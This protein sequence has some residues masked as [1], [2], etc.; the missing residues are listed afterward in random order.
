L[1]FTGYPTEI[2]ASKLYVWNHFFS[3]IAVVKESLTTELETK[4]NHLTPALCGFAT[5]REVNF[6]RV[7]Q[8]RNCVAHQEV[9]DIPLPE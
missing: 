3:D 6:M 5:L 4:K 7:T 1:D 2:T 8:I 9:I